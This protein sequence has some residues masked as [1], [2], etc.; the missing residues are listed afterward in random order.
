[1]CP[2]PVLLATIL[3]VIICFMFQQVNCGKKE[4]GHKIIVSSSS[5]KCK[6]HTVKQPVPVPIPIPVHH[7]EWVVYL[8]V[9]ICIT[10]DLSHQDAW[11]WRRWRGWC[12]C[13]CSNGHSC[14]ILYAPVF[15][16]FTTGNES[17]RLCR[18]LTLRSVRIWQS[19]RIRWSLSLR[20]LWNVTICTKSLWLWWLWILTI[21]TLL[22][23]EE[24][25]TCW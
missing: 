9:S 19:I 3:V 17:I 13:I 24:E 20:Q 25:V 4:Q 23:E 8:V 14:R 7:H 21:G 2:N 18:L 15:S 1:M 11:T 16:L 5:K 6:C 10:I 22:M 12:R